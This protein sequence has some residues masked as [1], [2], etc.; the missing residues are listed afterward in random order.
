MV[1]GKAVD[2][3]IRENDTWYAIDPM[4]NRDASLYL[5]TRNVRLW[6]RQN[7]RDKSVLNT[8]AYTGSLGVAA[9]A[10]GAS[11]VVQLDLNRQFLNVAKDSYTL[12]GF[13]RVSAVR[14]RV[15]YGGG[16]CYA[17]SSSKRRSLRPT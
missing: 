15:G 7:L 9:L 12:N 16:D 11:R 17:G 3:K 10:G 4:I 2:R 1:Q 5:D 14:A 13:G 8:F 6:A